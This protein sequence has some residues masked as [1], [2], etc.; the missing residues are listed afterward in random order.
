MVFAPLSSSDLSRRH[1]S[2]QFARSPWPSRTFGTAPTRVPQQ[3]HDAVAFHVTRGRCAASATR[4][5]SRETC[6][7]ANGR[8]PALPPTQKPNRN[9]RKSTM[10]CSRFGVA[11][12]RNAMDHDSS[13]PPSQGS[14]S[15][16]ESCKTAGATAL[17]TSAETLIATEFGSAPFR[18]RMNQRAFPSSW[19]I[20]SA[21]SPT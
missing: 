18:R 12:A 14:R 13:K 15:D 6:K 4:P 11:L 17:I 16:P 9:R 21:F 8:N 19:A 3:D 1:R 10:A 2:T 5:A 20:T 7:H